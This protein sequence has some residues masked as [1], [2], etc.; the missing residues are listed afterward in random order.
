MNINLKSKKKLKINKNPYNKGFLPKG[1]FWNIPQ[2]KHNN[3]WYDCSIKFEENTLII[4][5]LI[6][7]HENSCTVKEHIA[8]EF[9]REE[10]SS[11]KRNLVLYLCNIH[12]INYKIFD[13]KNT[14]VSRRK[15]IFVFGL[16][17][18][19]SMSYYYINLYFE[20]WFMNWIANSLFAQTVIIFLTLSGFINIFTPF[21]IQKEI[22]EKDVA[23]IALTRFKEKEKEDELNDLIKEHASF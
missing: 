1:M 13:F 9:H 16:A 4:S 18:S 3:I 20:N 10:L 12:P 11:L 14:I 17:I 2:I 23:E 8:G 6:L 15:S 21:T 7:H 5:S 19:L 22:T